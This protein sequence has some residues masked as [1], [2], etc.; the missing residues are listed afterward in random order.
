MKYKVAA[1]LPMKGHSERIPFKNIKKFF[2]KPLFCMIIDALRKSEYI[3]KIYI[4]TDSDTIKALIDKF[5]RDIMIIDRPK[6]M[7]GDRMSMNKIIAYDMGIIDG[8]HFLQTHSTNPLLTTRTIDTCVKTYFKNIE[9]GYDSLFG[10]SKCNA[11]F[12]DHDFKPVNHDPGN[13]IRT[14]DLPPLYMENSCLYLFSRDSF[15]S[16]KLNRI[17][18]KPYLFEINKVESIDIDNEEDFFIAEKIYSVLHPGRR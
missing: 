4:D 9:K 16:N 8:K 14:Q 15:T 10:V 6:R 18:K 1:L 13:L 7:V 17:G 3:S 12:Y 11:R 2:G 5:Y